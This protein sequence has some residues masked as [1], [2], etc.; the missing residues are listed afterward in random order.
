MDAA[1]QKLLQALFRKESRSLLQ[2]VSEADPWTTKTNHRLLEQVITLAREEQTALAKM[3]R[4]LLKHHVLE[5]TPV[6]YP[7]N[8]TTIN[9]VALEHLLPLLIDNERKCIAELEPRVGGVRDVQ[10][11]G[12][13]SEYLELKRRH[14]QALSATDS[15]AA[16][17]PTPSHAPAHA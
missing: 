2:Y 11:R 7:S 8:F 10:V 6:N 4:L 14:L 5:P 1:S 3:A 9:F 15:P 12:L 16:P 17:A 13:V